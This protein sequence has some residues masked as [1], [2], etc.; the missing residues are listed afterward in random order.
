VTIEIGANDACRSTIADQTP[1][2]TFRGQVET[3]TIS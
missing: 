3:A 1:T 2:A